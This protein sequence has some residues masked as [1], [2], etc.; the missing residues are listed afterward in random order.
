MATLASL[1]LDVI[2]MLYGSTQLERPGEDTLLT[3]VS[4]ASDTT[5]K[6]ATP[7]YWDRGDYAEYWDGTGT[8]GEVV[9][10]ARDA[11]S[12]PDVTVRRAQRRTTAA[13]SYANGDVFLKNPPATLT[14]IQRAINET[15]DVDLNAP[16]HR[17]WY[18][19]KR[20]ITPVTAKHRYE[21]NASDWRVD[22][23]YQIDLAE[24]AIGTAS[25]DE[26]GGTWDDTW[27]IT[28][29]DLEV[30][31]HVRFTT[32]G[33]NATGYA[34][35]TDYWVV[36]SS[37]D[38]FQLS[39]S[40]GGSAVAGTGDGSGWVLVRQLPSFHPFPNAWW[41]ERANVGGNVSSTGGVLRVFRWYSDDHTIYYT[42]RTK[43]SSSAISSLPAEMVD[44]V[45]L[46]ATA[47]LLGQLVLHDRHDPTRAQSR[48]A[49]LSPSQPFADAGYF[50]NKFDEAKRALHNRLFLENKPDVRIRTPRNKRG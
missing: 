14:D 18:P 38:D 6:F 25:F 41:E 12:G 34:A 50:K 9:V 35:D 20:T 8:A 46:G 39:A 27:T 15:I 5:F 3:A 49:G 1:T 30:G 48:V 33:T 7:K 17:V 31:D 19:S 10:V 47:R 42:A 37:G 16:P 13:S 22:E 24:E 11:E 21:M 44:M 2:D 40:L 23:M 45:P 32:A 36:N 28:G 43:P 26:S 4:S 29:H